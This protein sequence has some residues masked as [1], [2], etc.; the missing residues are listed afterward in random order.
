MLRILR[1]T[2]TGLL[3]LAVASLAMSATADPAQFRG[4]SDHCGVYAGPPPAH[5]ILKWAFR[6]GAAVLA[7]P[8]VSGATVYIASADHFLYA[9]EAASGKLQ[10][11]FDAHGRLT[12]SP[13]V[14]EGR[15]F[16]TSLDGKLYAVDAASGAA[17]WTFATEGERRFT[18][19]GM[20]YAAPP[21]ETMPDPWDLFLSSP[22]VAAGVVYFG[23]GDHSVYAVAASSG[24]LLWKFRTGNVVHAS[25]AVVGGRLYVGG[26][27]SYFYA[28]DAT[29]GALVW[30]FKTGDD[31][32]GHLMTGL[33]GSAAV[34]DGTVYFG[35]RDGHVYAVDAQSGQQRWQFSTNG[36]WVV[37]SP[38]VVNHRVYVTTSDSQRFE[39]LDSLTGAE[40]YAL[41]Y[42]IYAFS[43]PA[44]AGGR[45]YFGTFDG[46]LHEVDLRQPA[47]RETFSVPGC[48]DS[49]RRFLDAKGQLRGELVWT[50]DTLD[51]AIVDLRTKV[52][53]LGSILSSPVVADGLVYFGSV[54]GSLYAVGS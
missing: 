50:G 38:A 53:S 52:F 33:P 46:R 30:R 42:A 1:L 5:L 15:V 35:S 45:A 12:S 13:A 17:A 6:T 31:D 16:I 7:S 41:P 28:L 14:S 27:D 37:A 26:F 10:W 4:G 40:V 2:H 22:A 8:A 43:S 18:A 54:D 32:A 11:K 19:P 29:T 34:A 47:Y 23:S 25:P 20:D 24:R 21:R 39:A 44:V 36:S 49:R 48:D 51:D 3:G 9:I